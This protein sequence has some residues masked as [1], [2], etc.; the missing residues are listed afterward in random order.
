MEDLLGRQ[1]LQVDLDAVRQGLD[2]RVVLVTGAAG[3]IGS[4]LRRQ[5]IEYGPKKIVC[6][7]RNEHGLALLQREC[8]DLHAQR[9]IVTVAADVG[10][11]NA[12]RRCFTE[13]Q[14]DFV[15]HAAAHKHV[16][17]MET[18]EVEAVTNN[19]FALTTLLDV[20]EEH[21]CR[22]FVLISSDKAVN[23]ASVMGATK[24]V[25]E[26]ILASRP[27]KTMRCVSVRFGN[28]LGSS[29][30]VIPILLNQ[31]RRGLPLTITHAGARRLFMTAREAVSLLLQAFTIGSHGDILVLEMGEPIN[32]LEMARSLIRLSGVSETSVNIEFIGLRAGEKL[33]EELFYKNESVTSTSCEE[34]KRARMT[35]G[36]WPELQLQL[37]ALRASLNQGGPDQIRARLRNI[38]PEFRDWKQVG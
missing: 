9:R 15:F 2:G 11:E 24:R 18:K 28:V 32:I 26:L 25:G 30:S 5:I 22:A 20:A 8:S 33:E 27:L 4:A 14:I 7:D 35:Y 21:S 10:D 34:I 3:S 12:I 16:P 17:E 6:V 19:I 13:H 29:G 23:P 31:L 1:P 37:E 38:V 36:S